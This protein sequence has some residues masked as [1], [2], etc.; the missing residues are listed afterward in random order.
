MTNNQYWTTGLPGIGANGNGNTL[1][2]SSGSNAAWSLAS[3][4]T[5]EAVSIRNKQGET[6][7]TFHHDGI[8]ETAGGKIHADEWVQITMVMKQFI[9][10]VAQ[11]EEFAK[12]YPYVKD[13]AHTWVMNEL[14][15]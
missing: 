2:I 14:G 5:S 4:V 10:D 9:M 6:V 7:L 12:K 8:I 3:N 1:A 15:K 11:D 13:M